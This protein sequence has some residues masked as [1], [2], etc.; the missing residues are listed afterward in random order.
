MK[1]QTPT[2][3]L[4]PHLIDNERRRK[5]WE[6]APCRWGAWLGFCSLAFSVNSPGQL[7][8][9][10]SGKPSEGLAQAKAAAVSPGLLNEWLREQSPAFNPWDLG[11]Q[12]RARYEI[13]E[14]GG[15]LPA[16]R[17]F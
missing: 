14:D 13:K 4:T 7:A 6:A 11:G 1:A 15:S 17:D 8:G 2:S 5:N 12:F 16:S 10:S 3:L 9:Q